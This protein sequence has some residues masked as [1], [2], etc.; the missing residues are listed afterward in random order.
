VRGI[1]SV[2][3]STHKN[4]GFVPSSIP[5]G[6]SMASSVFPA[7]YRFGPFEL[8]RRSCE[9]RRNGRRVRMQEKPLRVLI[10]L[11][12]RPGEVV[13]RAELHERLWPQD[14]FVVFEDGLNTAVRKLREVLGD[15]PQAPRYIE[16]IR[17]R[18]YRLITAV[19]AIDPKNVALPESTPKVIPGDSANHRFSAA[20]GDETAN[21]A[22][23]QTVAQSGYS[24]NSNEHEIRPDAEA[25][26]LS[27]QDLAAGGGSAIATAPSASTIRVNSARAQ[28]SAVTT[29]TRGRRWVFYACAGALFAGGALTAAWWLMPVSG[30]HNIRVQQ[31]TTSGGIDFLVKPVTDGA[32]VY[33][34]ERAGGH[35]NLIETVTQRR[36]TAAGGRS[37]G[38]YASDGHITGPRNVSFG[39]IYVPRFAIFPVAVASSGW[40]SDPASQHRVGRGCMDAGWQPHSLWAG[41]RAVDRRG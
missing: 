7:G 38:E 40:K 41:P 20:V 4:L 19:S 10:A 39:T 13:S 36:G 8:D 16:T 27:P 18:G 15:D 32:R 14:T 34:V 3:F 29:S 24:L 1:A 35:W 11:A 33:Y 23:P 17:G 12:E 2:L 26:Q 6:F 37:R 22:D 21:P 9:L 31:L 5:G 30:L 28:R 25:R